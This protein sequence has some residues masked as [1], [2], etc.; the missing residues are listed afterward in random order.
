MLVLNGGGLP[1]LLRCRDQYA[2]GPTALG[3]LARPR[4]ADRI[5]DTIAA[6]FTVGVDNDAFSGWDLGRFVAMLEKIEHAAWGRRLTWPERCAPFLVPGGRPW[7]DMVEP[8][9]PHPGLRFVT[10]PDVPF[11]HNATL[12]RFYEWGPLMA[13]MPSAFCA[14]DG[15]TPDTVPWSWPNLTAVFIAGGDKFKLSPMAAS[16]ARAAKERGLWVHAGRVN[17]RKRIRY[18]LGLDCV[19]SIDG[20][21]FDRFR[22]THLPWALQLAARHEPYQGVFL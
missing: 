15:C 17:S 1:T 19:D 4:H 8:P 10:V 18:F 20:T 16:I 2:G 12:R 3:R 11:D 14:Q 6:G 7:P 13:N 22:N 9:R 5:A 21:G